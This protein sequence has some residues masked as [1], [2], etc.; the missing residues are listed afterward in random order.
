MRE[1]N[2]GRSNEEALS[3][4]H[5][6]RYGL[7]M[8]MCVCVCVCVLHSVCLGVCHTHT[9]ADVC[10]SQC[11]CSLDPPPPRSFY[12]HAPRGRPT[13]VWSLPF[14]RRLLVGESRRR[15]AAQCVW[16]GTP[17]GRHTQSGSLKVLWHSWHPFFSDTNTGP[18]RVL[19]CTHNTREPTLSHRTWWNDVMTVNHPE[20]YSIP[21]V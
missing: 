1:S 7:C 12:I 17:P 14:S 3:W 19:S 16:T 8:S 2:K 6:T 15:W 18:P 13:H 5:S 11:K 9:V 4:M 21:E 10:L 20:V